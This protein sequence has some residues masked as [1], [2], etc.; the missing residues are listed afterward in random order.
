MYDYREAMKE[1]ILEYIRENID[2]SEFDTLEELESKLNDELWAENS[3][4]GNASGSYYFSNW[5][6]EEALCHNFDLLSEALF[7][8]GDCETLLRE[9][10]A[11][12]ADVT[13]RCYLLGECI[14]AA[15]ES[16]KEDFKNAHK[17]E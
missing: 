7:D 2:V 5:K 16:I 4:T 11:E 8:F 3:I 10:D 9:F 17:E 6:A 13:I 15:L 1:D 12:K 14:A